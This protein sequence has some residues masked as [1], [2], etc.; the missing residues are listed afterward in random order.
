[1]KFKLII[2]LVVGLMFFVKAFSQNY[3]FL[4]PYKGDNG[5]WGYCDINNK[6]IVQPT[7]IFAELHQNGIAKVI[8]EK[9]QHGLIND[10][11]QFLIPFGDYIVSTG[12]NEGLFKFQAIQPQNNYYGYYTP[13]STSTPENVRLEDNVFVVVKEK[14]RL[15]YDNKGKLLF[16][17]NFDFELSIL[18]T[19]TSSLYN[20]SP[21]FYVLKNNTEE[22]ISIISSKGVIIANKVKGYKAELINVLSNDKPISYVSIFQGDLKED[23]LDGSSYNYDGGHGY[24]D[25]YTETNSNNYMMNENLDNREN[26]KCQ[27]MDTNG[28]VIIPF[29]RG[30]CS[31]TEAKVGYYSSVDLEQG[32]FI[33]GE[34][35]HESADCEPKM[36]L[37]LYAIEVDKEIIK[38]TYENQSFIGKAYE[39]T[40]YG[41]T[42]YESEAEKAILKIINSNERFNSYQEMVKEFKA[43]T[44]KINLTPIDDNATEENNGYKGTF[45]SFSKGDKTLIY[46]LDKSKATLYKQLDERVEV[47]SIYYQ[48]GNFYCSYTGEYQYVYNLSNGKKELR[49]ENS[50]IE[51]NSITK[52]SKL[53][54][55]Q[56]EGGFYKIKDNKGNF[57]TED[58]SSYGV[59]NKK[60]QILQ[61][62]NGTKYALV[63]L[64]K[65]EPIDFKYHVVVEPFPEYGAMEY[66]VNDYD[67]D[68][69]TITPEMKEVMDKKENNYPRIAVTDQ[70]FTVLGKE[71]ETIIPIQ[72]RVLIFEDFGNT[73]MIGVYQL[74]ASVFKEKKNIGYYGL[75]GTPYF[76]K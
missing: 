73:K 14:E 45:V 54:L 57:V 61:L 30:I 17:D 15:W 72:D 55:V 66:W 21:Y 37:G 49:Y 47:N 5:K 69:I 6:T 1:M 25:Y 36:L 39:Q 11:G 3:N 56:T 41:S 53:E 16:T 65:N 19:Y 68:N 23:D 35:I 20:K 44:D 75:N 7:F 26:I 38:P 59:Y 27:V 29:S 50:Q 71:A 8:N 48:N 63:N 24:G 10:K 42:G 31:V 32:Y 4:F 12:K 52:G 67:T 62:Y 58:F 9:D 2:S 51:N 18:G 43:I 33:I 64:N 60:S 22:E 28:K 34:L 74:T 46:Q 70:G 13:P 76:E 40:Y